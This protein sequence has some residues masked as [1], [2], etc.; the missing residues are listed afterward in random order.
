MSRES[1]ILL[2]VAAANL[3]IYWVFFGLFAGGLFR[4]PD[5][6]DIGGMA[7]AIWLAASALWTFM[8]YSTLM[9]FL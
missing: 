5:W 4:F 1:W 8:C 2:A 7:L 6:R 9:S 3:P